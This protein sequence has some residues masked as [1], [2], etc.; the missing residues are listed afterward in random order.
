MGIYTGAEQALT[1]AWVEGR[2]KA[3]D[4]ITP[5]LGDRI[6]LDVAPEGTPYPFV[7][8]QCQEPPRDVR[9]VGSFRVMVD[10]L[11]VAKAVAQVSSYRDSV[12]PA[13]V[14][15]DDDLVIREVRE[16]SA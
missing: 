9:G 2:L 10:T 4:T 16:V 15:H 8:Y 3:F 1:D 12:D 11:Y 13:R 7:V 14:D 5:G 6:F